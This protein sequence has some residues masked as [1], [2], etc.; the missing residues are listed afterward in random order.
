MAEDG[1]QNDQF[2]EVTT[3]RTPVRRWA[4]GDDYRSLAAYLCDRSIDFHTGDTIT[5]DGGYTVF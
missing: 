2:R 5:F 1:Y 3:K 4:S